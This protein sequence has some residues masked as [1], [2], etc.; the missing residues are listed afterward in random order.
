LRHAFDAFLDQPQG[1]L[2]EMAGEWER[3]ALKPGK[4]DHVPGPSAVLTCAERL[5]DFL[6]RASQ[7]PLVEAIREAVLDVGW[8]GCDAAGLD[9]GIAA[10]LAAQPP[11]ESAADRAELEKRDKRLVE[12]I[13]SFARQISDYGLMKPENLLFIFNEAETN[14]LAADRAVAAQPQRLAGQAKLPL[15]QAIR[16]AVLETMKWDGQ[17]QNDE[18]KTPEEVQQDFFS[19]VDSAIAAVL[20][21]Q[22]PQLNEE[23]A[24]ALAKKVDDWYTQFGRNDLLPYTASESS[25]RREKIQHI[26]ALLYQHGEGR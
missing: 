26:A 17:R 14:L 16:E 9:S 20:A 15:V 25:L 5:R 22:P 2:G 4:L 19:S 13:S 3:D 23:T 12:F 18:G 10:V 6:A 24:L 11:F 7:Q 8:I 21:A 1:S